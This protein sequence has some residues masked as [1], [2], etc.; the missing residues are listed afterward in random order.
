MFSGSVAR[1]GRQLPSQMNDHRRVKGNRS[2]EQNSA[3]DLLLCLF[4]I[5]L[6]NPF[7]FSLPL[8]KASRR[9]DRLRERK[10]PA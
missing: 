6:I 1:G 3:Y 4:I 2:A 10:N 8:H 9:R 5:V 7:L